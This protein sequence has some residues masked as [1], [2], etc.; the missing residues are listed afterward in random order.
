MNDNK[1]FIRELV[2]LGNGVQGHRV[3]GAT[4]AETKKNIRRVFAN[5]RQRS[6]ARNLMG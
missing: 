2:E 5:A 3:T 1:K 4:K 6:E